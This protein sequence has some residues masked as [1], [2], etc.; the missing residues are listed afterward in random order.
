MGI[1]NVT[2]ESFSDGGRRLDPGRAAADAVRMVADGVDLIDVGGE[3]TRPGA[4]AVDAD[5]EWRRVG[6]VLE[7]LCRSVDVPVSIDTYKASVARRALDAG[8]TI[9]NDISGL[10]FDPE[11][12]SVVAERRAAVVLMHTR[13]RPQDMYAQATYADVVGEVIDEL[14]ERGRLAREAGIEAERIIFDPGFGFAKRAADSLALLAGLG[15][16]HVLGA[17]LLSGPSRKSFLGV[18]GAA[19]PDARDW[20]TAAA[21][22][23]SILAGAHIVRVHDVAAMVQVARAADAISERLRPEA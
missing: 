2:P 17:P 18:S 11:L 20:A 13:G 5:E 4:Q 10:T 14:S 9:V 15:R 21:V 8:A 12:A 23:A 6:P 19:S 22:T 1:V 3:S 7:R 16:L